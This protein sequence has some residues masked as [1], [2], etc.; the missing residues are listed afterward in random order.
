MP[1]AYLKRADLYR[2]LNDYESRAAIP[3]DLEK[4]L[5]GDAEADLELR[6]GDTLRVW[7]I[8]EAVFIPEKTTQ[9]YG[10]VQRP[11]TYPYYE[12][13]TL[14]DLILQGAV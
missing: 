9:L 5:A 4:A 3:V 13:M 12:G 1:N 6:P 11:D 7:A 10:A 8:R 2:Y 14:R